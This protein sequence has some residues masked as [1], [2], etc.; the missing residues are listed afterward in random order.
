MVSQILFSRFTLSHALEL[1]PSPAQSL[2]DGQRVSASWA[3]R[4]SSAATKLGLFLNFSRLL[5]GLM[6]DP[7]G[8]SARYP[9]SSVD[10][11]CILVVSSHIDVSYP[12]NSRRAVL[13]RLNESPRLHVHPIVT[14]RPQHGCQAGGFFFDLPMSPWTAIRSSC[15]RQSQGRGTSG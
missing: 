10:H 12:R 4:R 11:P 2:P 9:T 15:P 6:L 14:S 13:Q 7:V 1:F 3:P 5:N 8:L